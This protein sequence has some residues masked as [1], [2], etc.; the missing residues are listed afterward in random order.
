MNYLNRNLMIWVVVVC[1]Y[2]LVV[3][4]CWRLGGL[5]LLRVIVRRVGRFKRLCSQGTD[6]QLT[7]PF[8]LSRRD[9]DTYLVSQL[10]F[11]SGC[12]LDTTH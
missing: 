9:L 2:R 4:Y 1:R 8:R 3:I 12:V 5:L 10:S 6:M 11:C 7:I